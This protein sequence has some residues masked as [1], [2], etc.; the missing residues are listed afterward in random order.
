MRI[1][2]VLIGLP[3]VGK[4]TFA[5]NFV[6]SNP[7]WM[8]ITLDAIREML[9][10]CYVYKDSD[11]AMVQ[12][13]AGFI[14]RQIAQSGR[15]AI[16]DDT[17]MVLTKASRKELISSLRAMFYAERVQI[18]AIVFNYDLEIC[19]NKRLADPRGVSSQQWKRVITDMVQEF[20]PVSKSEGFDKITYIDSTM[21][22]K[23]LI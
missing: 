19:L 21:K 16:L 18:R 17:V 13:I 7:E 23:D 22:G 1:I 15:N 6:I 12:R 4:T 9:Y 10:G 20:E 8:I 14:V 11:Q 2:D 5:R 3:G